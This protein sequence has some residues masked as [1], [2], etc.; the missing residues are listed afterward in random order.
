MGTVLVS[1]SK[2]PLEMLSEDRPSPS[3]NVLAFAMR[4]A[5]ANRICSPKSQELS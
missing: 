3:Q 4:A 5:R 1:G 2:K